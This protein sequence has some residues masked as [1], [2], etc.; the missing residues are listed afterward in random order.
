MNNIDKNEFIHKSTKN[1]GETSLVNLDIVN[2]INYMSS[3]PYQIN[4]DILKHILILYA[5][6][7]LFAEGAK[8]NT[9]TTSSTNFSSNEVKWSGDEGSS[10]PSNEKIKDLIKLNLHPNTRNMYKLQLKHKHGEINDIL[11]HNSH[12]YSDRSIILYSILFAD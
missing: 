3:I 9:T 8:T 1:S 12:F 2:C 5:R 10:I 7:S 11:I 4:T 6:S